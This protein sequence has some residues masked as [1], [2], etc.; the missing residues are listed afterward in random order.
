M[1]EQQ[2]IGRGTMHFFSTEG[3]RAEFS[4]IEV[5][6]FA[7]DGIEVK[8]RIAFEGSLVVGVIHL[9]LRSKSWS[10]LEVIFILII[11]LFCVIDLDIQ[12]LAI[13]IEHLVHLSSP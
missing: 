7:E 3:Y 6:E 10:R 4:K 13:R 11:G 8:V 9:K 2:R 5:D 1:F 12:L